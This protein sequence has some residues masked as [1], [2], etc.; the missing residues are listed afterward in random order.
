MK[1]T[2]RNFISVAGAGACIAFAPSTVAGQESTDGMGL[3][4]PA[5]QALP[6]F[7]PPVHLDAA[8]IQQLTGDQQVLLTTLQGIVNRREP[9]LYWFLQGDNTDQTW[10]NTINVPYTIASDPLSL[11]AK[12]RDE[13]RGAIV[14]DPTVSDTINVA[15]SLAGLN[16]AVVAS[17]DLA[18][19]YG[20]PIIEDLRGRFSNKIDAYNWVLDNYWPQLTHRLLTAVS[21][22]SPTFIPGVSWVTLFEVT[23]PVTDASNKALYTADLSGLLGG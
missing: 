17:A 11:I 20:L 9:R 2:R 13:I 23:Q 8:N 7:L 12:Y 19:Q 3:I 21:P 22:A 4:W 15:T 18:N 16:D 10:L 5:N 6:S 14:Y 1:V